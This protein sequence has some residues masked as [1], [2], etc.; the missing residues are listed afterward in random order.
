MQTNQPNYSFYR[1]RKNK[2]LGFSSRET[3][4]H[5]IQQQADEILIRNRKKFSVMTLAH[6]PKQDLQLCQFEV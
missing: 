6:H 1:W 4:I 5:T 2:A 3:E